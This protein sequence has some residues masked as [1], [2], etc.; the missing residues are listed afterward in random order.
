[1]TEKTI[2]GALDMLDM[3]ASVET[4]KIRYE[5]ENL[6]KIKVWALDHLGVD[7]RAGDHVKIVQPIPTDNDGWHA[8][9][10]ALHVGAR[11]V[12]REIDFN[13]SWG[14]WQ[15]LFVPDREWTVSEWGSG[16]RRYWHGPA[17]E[18]PDGFQPPTKY[19]QEHHPEGTRH[20]YAFRVEWLALDREA[21]DGA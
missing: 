10:E 21:G 7:Y 13:G 14:Y 19:D 12:V 15:A 4:G 17:I 5:V 2:T 20:S 6:R 9:R 18:T 3:I 11:G 16:T 1:M 8:S